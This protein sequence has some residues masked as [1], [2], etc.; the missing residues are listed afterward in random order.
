VL[1]EHESTDQSFN[2]SGM[3]LK[4]YSRPDTEWMRVRTILTFER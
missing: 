3:T 1:P 2:H 4:R